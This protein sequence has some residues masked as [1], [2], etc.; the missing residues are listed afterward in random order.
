MAH[1]AATSQEQLLCHG[2]STPLGILAGSRPAPPRLT[3]VNRNSQPRHRSRLATRRSLVHTNEYDH[4]SP[5]TN[6]GNRLTPYPQM[7]SFVAESPWRATAA[8]PVPNISA[9]RTFT[10]LQP[11]ARLSVDRPHLGG[12]KPARWP[13]ENR[14]TWFDGKNTS[15]LGSTVQRCSARAG[16]EWCGSCSPSFDI[17]EIGTVSFIPAPPLRGLMI[18]TAKV[19][20]GDFAQSDLQRSLT[21]TRIS[22]EHHTIGGAGTW[23]SFALIG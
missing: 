3:S 20:G 23:R 14:L 1:D 6:R 10:Q 17:N 9:I 21:G 4:A 18:T 16:L 19:P 2:V 12:R 15:S 5:Q 7:P 11:P 13:N 22:R 8:L